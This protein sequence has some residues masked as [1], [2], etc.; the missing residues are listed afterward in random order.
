MGPV[1][2]LLFRNGYTLTGHQQAEDV[3]FSSR[4]AYPGLAYLLGTAN[5]VYVAGRL[6]VLQPP[7]KS[8][9]LS[10]EN[11]GFCGMGTTSART[12]SFT[13]KVQFGAACG[14]PLTAAFDVASR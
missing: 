13:S 12:A 8:G 2:G 1:H 7:S 4:E 6:E 5:P 14:S 11:Y 3:E 10:S 9:G